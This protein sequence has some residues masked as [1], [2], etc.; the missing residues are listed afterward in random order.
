VIL[1][2]LYRPGKHN[3]FTEIMTE[4]LENAFGLLSADDRV[5]AIVVTGHGNIFCAGADLDEGLGKGSQDTT[6]THRD[7]AV[8]CVSQFFAAQSR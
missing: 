4:E 7:G 8:G 6:R 2:T 5:K 1:I 3:A